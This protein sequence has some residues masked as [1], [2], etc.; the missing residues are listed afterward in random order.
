[1]PGEWEEA[2]QSIVEAC[3]R[4]EATGLVAGASGNVSVRLAPAEGRELVAITPSRVPYRVLR[5]DQVLVIDFDAEPVAGE[6]VPSS[7]T[8]L[9]LAVYRARRDVG[10]VIHTHSIYAS[11]FAVAGRDLPAVIDEQVIVLG[12]AVR[13]A[14]YGAS[15]TEELAERG[16]RAL[17]QRQAA[18][19]R[20]HGVLGVGRD[21]EEALDVVTLVERVAQAVAF[22]QLLGGAQPLPREVLETEERIFRM[23]HGLPMEE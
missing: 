14:E 1:M 7:E 11:A 10:A 6:G 22:A 3:R 18:L 17:G 23:Q 9:H 13:V 20:N 2:R 15:A 5:P 19:L 8:L 16:V 21:L 4:L 12:G